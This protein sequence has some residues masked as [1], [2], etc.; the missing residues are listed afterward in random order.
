MAPGAGV[1]HDGKCD[2][3]YGN[4]LLKNWERAAGFRLQ[5]EA[6]RGLATT[7]APVMGSPGPAPSDARPPA[8]VSPGRDDG[9]LDGVVAPTRGGRHASL[10]TILRT[11]SPG[12]CVAIVL[13]ACS[14][15]SHHRQFRD[16]RA[17]RPRRAP[18]PAAYAARG[19]TPPASA[20]RP[21]Q[22]KTYTTPDGN[23]LFDYPPDWTVKDRAIGGA[24]GSL[25]KIPRPAR[26]VDR[27]PADKHCDQAE[28]TQ[29][30]RLP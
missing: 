19:R 8:P 4:T 16:G 6:L 25:Y 27:N 23:S 20:D 5:S 3:R 21:P 12:F 2:A 30:F 10:R 7:P 15:P 28:S 1:I 14:A 18:R 13:A 9:K 29:K 11:V 24:R 26:K 17:Q 22:W